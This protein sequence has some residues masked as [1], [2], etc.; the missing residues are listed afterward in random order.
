MGGTPLRAT[1][2][3]VWIGLRKMNIVC[4]DFETFWRSRDY[5]LS[6]MGPLDYIRDE[7]FDAFMVGIVAN[8]MPVMVYTDK[9]YVSLALRQYVDDVFVAHNGSGFDHLILSERFGLTPHNLWDTI[10][11][12]RWCGASVAAGG[13]SHALL[14]KLFGHG[15]KKPGTVVSDNKHWPQDFTEGEREYFAQYCADDVSQMRKNLAAMLPYVTDDCLRF[16]SMTARMATEPVFVL[17]EAILSEY[18]KQLDME[19]DNA[20]R[21]LMSLFRFGSLPEF[22]SA[23][24]SADK[25]AGMLRSLGVEPPV[26]LSEKKTAT[27]IQKAEEVGNVE[28]VNRLRRD[29]VYT[30]AFSKTDIDFL[31]LAEHDDPRVRLLV[32]TRLEFNSSIMRSR[33]E[34]LLKFAKHKKPIPIMLSAFK[35]HTSRY[36]AG[37]GE[38]KTDSLNF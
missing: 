28:E 19:A 21:E 13:E 14:T 15:E 6:K 10:C 29:G 24:R 11:I 36:S 17:D 2:A 22:F 16:I 33:A 5:T 25:F 38:G 20:R 9:P 30:Y 23:L 35:A 4:Y 31:N 34:T 26:K 12:A 1:D 3:N 27:A 37:S 7:R 18:I 32:E 8:S